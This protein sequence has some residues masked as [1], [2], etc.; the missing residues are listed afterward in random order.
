GSN[1][2]NRQI[3][4]KVIVAAQYGC[5]SEYVVV[6]EDLVLPAMADLTAQENAAFAVNYMTAWIALFKLA[7]LQPED[8][9]LI[10][11]ASGGVGT[12]AL[13]LARSYGSYLYATAGTDEKVRYLQKLGAHTAI[14][15]CKEDF[16]RVIREKT[17]GVDVI[18]EM[19]GGNV[20]KKSLRLLLPFGRIIVMGFA[21]FNL[22]KMNPLSWIKTWRDIPRCNISDMSTR[23][24]GIMSSHL[25]YLLPNTE[26][27]HKT[28]LELVTY[29]LK[30]QIHPLIG[31]VFP[32]K[33]M[34]EAHTVMQS[35]RHTGKIVIQMH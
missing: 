32:F 31:S 3:G 30:H 34:A 6:H 33:K 35:R 28:W 20:F 14:N 1:V 2:K 4:E 5:Y 21:S 7:R 17:K 23:S 29:T 22:N 15:Y 18:I 27:M 26:L 13:N 16:E 8:S 12:A 19:I 11:A 24:Y 9:V 25:G 10:Q